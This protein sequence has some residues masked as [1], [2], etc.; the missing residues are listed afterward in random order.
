MKHLLDDHLG[1]NGSTSDDNPLLFR[2]ATPDET[3]AFLWAL[4]AK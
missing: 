4:Y 3:R 1:R 2:I